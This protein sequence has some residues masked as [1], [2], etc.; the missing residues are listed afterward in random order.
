MIHAYIPRLLIS[1][2]RLYLYHSSHGDEKMKH[3]DKISFMVVIN[4]FGGDIDFC[5]YRESSIQ[6]V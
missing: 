6:L 5:R 3:D 2:T 4:V 1:I